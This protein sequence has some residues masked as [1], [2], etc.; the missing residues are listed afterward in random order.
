MMD[1]TRLFI[2]KQ[3]IGLLILLFTTTTLSGQLHK[4]A[5]NYFKNG[6]YEKAAELYIKLYNQSPTNTFY[7]ERYVDALFRANKYRQAEKD[8]KK[9]IKKRPELSYLYVSLGKA[10][11]YQGKRN[12]AE[13]YYEKALRT[14]RPREIDI[15]RM[16]NLFMRYGLANYAI[17][18]YERGEELFGQPHK[19][20]L[21]RGNIHRSLGNKEEMIIAY[22]DYL[23]D[24]PNHLN[25]IKSNFS[26]YLSAEDRETLAAELYARLRQHPEFMPYRELLLWH[27]LQEKDYDKAL[28]IAIASDKLDKDH[29]AKVIYVAQT[30]FLQRDYDVAS[31][32]YQYI[33]QN[34]S[35]TNPYYF[36]A[37]TRWLESRRHLILNNPDHTE[38]DLRSLAAEYK[39][40][41]DMHGLN[42]STAPVA[43]EYART[44]I[45]YV[46]DLPPAIEM[47]KKV[48]ALQGLDPRSKA[49]AKI[50]L[51]DA[52]LIANERWEATLLYSQVD[53][54][55]R[56]DP[57]G[58]EARYKNAMLAYYFGDFDWAREQFGIL[59]SA[60]SRL[61]SNDA[62]DREVFIME[63][64]GLDTSMD[65]MK[66]LAKA[67]L[68]IFQRKYDAA[69]K[70]L[71]SLSIALP[72]H[73]IIDDVLYLKGQIFL[74][75]KQYDE[76]IKV[77]EELITK[78][79][80]AI[81]T[82]NALYALAEL[83]EHTL[84]Q[85]KKAMKYYEK[86]FIDYPSSTFAIEARER[87]RQLQQQ[88][89]GKNPQP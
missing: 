21:L 82:D 23:W 14:L 33:L 59:K 43:I 63:N 45:F 6:E 38:E 15:R 16:A 52:Y 17:K 74:S 47:L 42:A 49:K 26:R 72:N 53:K 58:E 75:Q 10:L 32:A 2:R 20:A 64:S 34:K 71:D 61:I 85:P 29:G 25:L 70:I 80:D 78:H 56:E 67:E 65:A 19:Y 87:Y 60:T 31:K 41:L 4:L 22:L 66:A 83:Y 36:T 9:Q 76:A 39:R 57:L 8:I 84:R 54:S 69:L 48:V 3:A 86:I 7:F 50:M 5:S 46:H 68:A 13:E 1:A 27:F 12:K 37:F 24:H 73:E 55:L 88:L 44:L 51:A 62:I 18:T 79:P 77:Y 30:A 28:E 35:R 40:F 89:Q 81:R 11:E